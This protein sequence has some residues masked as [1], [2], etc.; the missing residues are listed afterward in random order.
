[1]GCSYSGSGGSV[2]KPLRHLVRQEGGLGVSQEA[3]LLLLQVII[4]AMTWQLHNLMLEV[5]AVQQ[6]L[7]LL[8]APMRVHSHRRVHAPAAVQPRRNEKLSKLSVSV[9]FTL[10][11]TCLDL[12]LYM[13]PNVSI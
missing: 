10:Q 9:S 7:H 3:I 11:V 1:V 6:Q 2:A 13:L 4:P 8:L 12:F 5:A